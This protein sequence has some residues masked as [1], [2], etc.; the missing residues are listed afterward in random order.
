MTLLAGPPAQPS[1]PGR[2]GMSWL[3]LAL[4]GALVVAL[5]ALAFVWREW[6][7]A[8][9][10]GDD[11]GHAIDV[12]TDPADEAEAAARD[13]AVKM[14]T[15]DYRTVEKDFAWIDRIGSEKFEKDFS[16]SSRPVKR[17][18]RVTRTQAQGEVMASVVRLKDEDHAHV[19][20]F[21]DQLLVDRGSAQPKLDTIRLRIDMVRQDGRWLVDRIESFEPG[22]A[23]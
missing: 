6:D 15:Y 2:R 19:L 7:Q 4:C 21:V 1:R 22:R 18:I 17:A 5:V 13:A 8:G 11:V 23:S 20:L 16:V 9:D 3:V 12:L 10:R 14:T